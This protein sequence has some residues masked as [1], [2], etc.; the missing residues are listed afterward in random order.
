MQWMANR[1]LLVDDEADIAKVLKSGL[2]KEGYQVDAFSDPREALAHFKPDYYDL[3]LLDIRMGPPNGF[4]LSRQ[5]L[6]RDSK[7]KVFFM[8]AFE[9]DLSESKVV[10]PSLKVDGFMK[11]P[12]AIKELVKLIEGILKPVD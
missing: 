8:T 2:G 9:V 7:P 10:F 11:K 6:E 5:L 3:L 12:L 4:E 1:I